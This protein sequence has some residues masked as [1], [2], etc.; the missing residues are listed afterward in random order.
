MMICKVT[1]DVVAPQKNE[2][3]ADNKLL[4]VQPLD[5]EGMRRRYESRASK[6]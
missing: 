6:S 4:I 3:L 1:G 5:L 2:H